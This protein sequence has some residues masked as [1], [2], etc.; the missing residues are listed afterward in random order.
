MLYKHS[1]VRGC[2]CAPVSYTHLD[3]Y[4]RQTTYCTAFCLIVSSD[5]L[6]VVL[7]NWNFLTLTGQRL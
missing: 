4:K 1:D 2:E 3:V 6:Y 7:A 5:R